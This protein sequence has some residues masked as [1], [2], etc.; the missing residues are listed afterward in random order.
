ALLKVPNHKL[1]LLPGGEETIERAATVTVGNRDLTE[2]R[3]TAL[4]FSPQA[5]WLDHNG[6]AASVSSW[7]SVVPNGVESSIPQLRDAQQKTDAAWS[8]RITRAL[9]HAPRGDLVIRNARL[10]DPRD[11][12]VTP[13][14]SVI[15]SGERIVRVGLDADLKPS[16][17]A[18]II[19][20][21]DQF[22]M[23][24]LWDNHQHFGDNDGAL[25]LANGVTSARDMANDTDSFLNGSRVSMM[26]P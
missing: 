5:I 23:P 13:A 16:A 11:L 1:P 7:F 20:A 19:D 15:V 21:H 12:R 4:G 6:T 17:N 24:G 3:I 22:L 10:F 8:E 18:E 25:D 9:A 14:T 26:A 2:Y